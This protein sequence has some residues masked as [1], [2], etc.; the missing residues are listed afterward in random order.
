MQGTFPYAFDARL[1]SLVGQS[2]HSL[3][4]V[5]PAAAYLDH[6]ASDRSH[7]LDD[8]LSPEPS[9]KMPPPAYAALCGRKAEQ[10]GIFHN[11]MESYVSMSLSDPDKPALGQADASVEE[12]S[13]VYGEVMDMTGFMRWISGENA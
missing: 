3:F 7:M 8:A 10:L 5:I 13:K 12:T 11:L 6:F 1:A 2:F 4:R 9:Y